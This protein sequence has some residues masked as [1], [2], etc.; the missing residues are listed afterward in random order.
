MEGFTIVDGVVA[1][2]I[3]LS[4]L[5]AY[6][7]GFVRELMAIAGWVG[8]FIL[9]FVFADQA[10]PLVKQIPVVG[11]FLGNNC[12]L[13]I[14]ASFAIVF[15]LALVIVSLFTPLFSS[16]IQNS[17]LGPV[18]QVLGFVFGVVRGVLLVAVA[19]F[20]YATV[21]PNQN[22]GMIDSS[23]SAAIFGQYVD[24][25]EAQDPEAA[26]GWI[27]KQYVQLTSACTS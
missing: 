27:Q 19:F 16:L 5:L 7:R 2:V 24:D 25:I 9:A 23:R 6:S 22:V 26:M 4:A 13:L 18:D 14:I 21:L 20:V 3:V 8:A 10:R 17:I 15:A 11:D 12:E 1:V